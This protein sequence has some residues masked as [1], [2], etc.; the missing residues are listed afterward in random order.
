MR[1]SMPYGGDTLEANLDW[2]RCL[3]ALDIADV[4][5]LPVLEAAIERAIASPIG[6]DK[7]LYALVQPGESVAI[8]VSDA[9]RHTGVDRILPGL[10]DGLNR[11]GI[12]D[13]DLHFVFATGSHRP[14]HEDEK[15]RILGHAMYRRFH[16]QA[17]AHDPT[18]ESNL[19]HLGTTSRGTPVRI[20]KRVHEC[21]RIVATG[22]VVLHYFGGYGGGRKS[23]VPGIAAMDTIAANHARNL[24]PH[25][26]RL[27]PAVQIGGLDGNPV[28]EDML[29]AARL[30]H[31][32]YIINTVLNR[33]GQIAAVF[34][35]ELDAAHR[36]AAQYA[37]ELYAVPIEAQ[38]DLV[39]ASS[40]SAKN[41]IQSHKALFNAYQAVKPDGH[42]IFACQAPEG[43]GGNKFKQWLSLGTKHAIIA[44]LRK[45]AEI[46]GQTALST[47]EKAR[48]VTFVTE[49]S[50]EQVAG[51]GGHK[52][53][54]LED[55]L[56]SVR[57]DL[58]QAGIPDPT[59]Y[60]MPSASYTVPFV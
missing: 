26:D 24:D 3:G 34:A 49:L 31:V 1:L 2:G 8:L 18:D 15:A 36:A 28:A 13:E 32:D 54:S 27:N 45:N 7:D 9:F 47:L 21:D 5:E 19:I 52:A 33:R 46:N 44:E 39:I 57:H 20:N 56:E 41:F 11:A 42:I 29:E 16:Q 4:P 22:A 6:L 48:I 40:G 59:Y 25:D 51:L 50:P 14:P 10:V 23:V 38:A 37:Y 43:Y 17:F 35:G 30:C 53:A 58:A 60:A 55:A 12:R